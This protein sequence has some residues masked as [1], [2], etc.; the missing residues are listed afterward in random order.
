M[1]RSLVYEQWCRRRLVLSL[2]HI[3][4]WSHGPR[5]LEDKFKRGLDGVIV[6]PYWSMCMDQGVEK[7][8]TVSSLLTRMGLWDFLI[9]KNRIIFGYLW[10][11]Y[12]L[13][14]VILYIHVFFGF[15]GDAH[16]SIVECGVRPKSSRL[17]THPT[18][19]V[20]ASAQRLKE[21]AYKWHFS[22]GNGP[23]VQ[24]IGATVQGHMHL[25]A[26]TKPTRQWSPDL[27]I[28]GIAKFYQKTNKKGHRDPPT[29]QQIFLYSTSAY[30]YVPTCWF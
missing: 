29:S 28:R 23:L 15:R 12:K 27:I 6:R 2:L 8:Y 24:L 26:A 22:I 9:E 25:P 11:V 17:Y 20:R 7:C 18:V 5:F 16:T 1:A 19:D 13:E 3:R 21:C 4:C 30:S 14:R 10:G